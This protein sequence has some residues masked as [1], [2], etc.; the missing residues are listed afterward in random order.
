MNPAS[1]SVP[2]D[3]MILLISAI[4]FII[5]K[6]ILYIILGALNEIRSSDQDNR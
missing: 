5:D 4:R 6:R 1:D 3:Y 2:S